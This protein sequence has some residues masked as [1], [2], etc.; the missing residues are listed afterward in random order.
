MF[1]KSHTSAFA[2]RVASSSVYISD[3]VAGNEM[4]NAACARGDG[5]GIDDRD[6][7]MEKG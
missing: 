1:A 2:A 5:E 4:L 7:K 3:R 6:C